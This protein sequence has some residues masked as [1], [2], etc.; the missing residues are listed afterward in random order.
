MFCCL[1]PEN[2]LKIMNVITFDFYLE[3]FGFFFVQ[4][5]LPAFAVYQG[6]TSPTI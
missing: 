5:I 6:T 1:L 2:V 4:K 3:A